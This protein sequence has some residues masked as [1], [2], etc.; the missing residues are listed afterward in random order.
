VPFAAS[1]LAPPP[2]RDDRL[3]ILQTGA[4]IRL[5]DGP[6][7]LTWQATLGQFGRLPTLTEMFGDTGAVVGNA[8]L[9]AESAF[10]GD[11]GVVL[12][13]ADAEPWR[14]GLTL[15]LFSYRYDQLIQLVQNSQHTARAENIASARIDGAELGLQLQ[16]QDML[17]L[18]AN[19]AL[20]DARDTSD[21]SGQAQRS[22]PARPEHMFHALLGLQLASFEASYSLDI[23]SGNALDRA[24]FHVVPERVFHGC[25]LAYEPTWAPGF[26]LSLEADNL[27][28]LRVEEVPVL[29]QPPGI[30]VMT[31]HAVADYLG[32]PLPGRTLFATL[33]YELTAGR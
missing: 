8:D 7:E 13:L 5:L 24:G 21:V 30:T 1:P 15:A 20:T 29:P 3:W 16:W 28:D 12:A 23:D 17:S 33:S 31:Q 22:L 10:G 18:D 2:D 26:R 32:V 4:S 6:L 19:Y 14:A 25:A 11:S 27:L 9:V